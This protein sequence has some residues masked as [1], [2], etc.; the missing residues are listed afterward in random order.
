MDK[1]HKESPAVVLLDTR[2]P[3]MDGYEV[4]RRIKENKGLNTKI[5]IYTAFIDAVNVARARE[6]GADDFMGKL[7]DFAN[8]RHGVK[9]LIQEK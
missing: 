7:S 5:I 1:I 3:G 4:C 2:L 6:V 9:K 8:L